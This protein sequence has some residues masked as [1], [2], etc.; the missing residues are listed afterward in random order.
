MK[1]FYLLKKTINQ[2]NIKKVL[3]DGYVLDDKDEL[4]RM[5]PRFGRTLFKSKSEPLIRQLRIDN[6]ILYHGDD[7]LYTKQEGIKSC[8]YVNGKIFAVSNDGELY[9]ATVLNDE[10]VAYSVS[11]EYNHSGNWYRNNGG[12]VFILKN[13]DYLFTSNFSDFSIVGKYYSNVVNTFH[14]DNCD[15]LCL[16]DKTIDIS[17]P[18]PTT[19]WVCD[20]PNFLKNHVSLSGILSQ[21]SNKYMTL[22]KIGDADYRIILA[23]ENSVLDKIFVVKNNDVKV[24]DFSDMISYNMNFYVR[25]LIHDKKSSVMKYAVIFRRGNSQYIGGVWRMVYETD[26]YE[27]NS[28]IF[29]E[30]GG[31]PSEYLIHEMT[32]EHYDAF[33]NKMMVFRQE[34]PKTFTGTRWLEDETLVDISGDNAVVINA[35]SYINDDVRWSYNHI[36]DVVDAIDLTDPTNITC[37]VDDGYLHIGD[38][39][40]TEALLDIWP[41]IRNI[42]P[43][44]IHNDDLGGSYTLVNYDNG[45][46]GY[47]D[48]TNRDG[49][50]SIDK[51]IN[52]DVVDKIIG[53]MNGPAFLTIDKE[54]RVSLYECTRESTIVKMRNLSPKPVG[55]FISFDKDESVI[56]TNADE[57]YKLTRNAIGGE[58]IKTIPVFINTTL[59]STVVSISTDNQIIIEDIDYGILNLDE[60]ES[61]VNCVSVIGDRVLIITNKRIIIMGRTTTVDLYVHQTGNIVTYIVRRNSIRNY[62]YYFITDDNLIYK[63]TDYDLSNIECVMLPTCDDISEGYKYTDIIFDGDN[64]MSFVIKNYENGGVKIL[65]HNPSLTNAGKLEKTRPV[66]ITVGNSVCLEKIMLDNNKYAVVTGPIHMRPKDGS[67]TIIH[68]QETGAN[69]NISAVIGEYCGGV[70]VNTDDGLILGSVDC[71]YRYRHGMNYTKIALTDYSGV[72]KRFY[73]RFDNSAIFVY[74]YNEETSKYRLYKADISNIQNES[75]SLEYSWSSDEEFTM[76]SNLD[77]SIILTPLTDRGVQYRTQDMKKFRMILSE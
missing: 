64:N 61:A 73:K 48:I 58:E 9:V 77:G 74:T 13:G 72:I 66:G 7:V 23:K 49:L 45:E 28:D 36:C 27:I 25:G 46:Y 43:T 50:P 41:N 56:S 29:E 60:G 54:R 68:Y 14:A 53:C 11:N 75:I 40:R 57:Q 63:H 6:G 71:L 20:L 70:F 51:T 4:Y 76:K 2:I 21:D 32:D 62:E 33:I 17:F 10:V 39:G 30:R 55:D 24:I 69:I 65:L 15:Y 12:V 35:P 8:G 67:T 5:S 19:K 38:V 1:L 37:P 42:I 3:E 59:I 16:D 52:S 34:M 31:M 22:Y 47:R 26:Y 18:H 44:N